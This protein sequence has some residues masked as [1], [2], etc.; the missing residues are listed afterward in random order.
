MGIFTLRN[1][2]FLMLLMGAFHY[3]STTKEVDNH[4]LILPLDTKILAFGDSLTLGTGATPSQSYPSILSELVHAPVINA[5][6][7]GEIS[8]QGLERLPKLLQEHKP[9]ILILCHGGNDIL[10]KVN[11]AQTKENLSKM[12]SLAREKGVYVLLVGVPIMGTLSFGISPL[13]YDVAKAHN[14]ELD[15]ES[16]KEIFNH[17]NTLKADRVHPNSEGYALMAKNI[18]IILSEH[19]HPSAKTF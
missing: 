4:S 12:V 6:I 18:A 17:E 16:L 15:D 10:R 13:Y 5:G 2:V 14:I 11:S 9:D 7:S 1:V 19:Y 8:A 3:F